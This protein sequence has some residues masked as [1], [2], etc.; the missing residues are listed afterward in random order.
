[1]Q[2]SKLSNGKSESARA[3]ALLRAVKSLSKPKMG[4]GPL[5]TN[6]TTAHRRKA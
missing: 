3:N 2:A 6:K 4:Y 1:M 5:D